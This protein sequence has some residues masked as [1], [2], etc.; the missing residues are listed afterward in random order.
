MIAVPRRKASGKSCR[1][2]RFEAEVVTRRAAAERRQ[3]LFEGV[4][5]P[6][7]PGLPNITAIGIELH[8][9]G[10]GVGAVEHRGA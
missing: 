7:R 1:R 3:D 5:A 4:E 6:S 2:P 10:L 9:Y 8:H